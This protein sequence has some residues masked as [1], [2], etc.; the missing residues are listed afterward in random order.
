MEQ[1]E[2][3]LLCEF[4]LDILYWYISNKMSSVSSAIQLMSF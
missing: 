1:S 3:K 2:H 4:T